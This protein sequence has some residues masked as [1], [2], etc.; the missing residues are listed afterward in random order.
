MDGTPRSLLDYLIK[1]GVMPNTARLVERGTFLETIS[2]IPEISSVAWTTIFTGTNPAEHGIFGFVDLQPHS[3]KIR[4][5]SFF[6]VRVPALWE[7]LSEKNRR[8]IIVNIPATYPAKPLLGKL[9]SGFVAIDLQKACWPK[10][11]AEEL[12]RAGYLID[13]DVSNYLNDREGLVRALEKSIEVRGRVILDLFVK[14]E[15]DLFW[16]VITETDRLHHFLFDAA[17]DEGHPL[18]K[19][20]V[21]VYG[22][23]DELLGEL[24]RRLDSRTRLFV[25]SDHGFTKVEREVNINFWLQE[26]GYL[27]FENSPPASLED[28]SSESIAFALDPARIFLNL[29]GRFPKGCVEPS[30]KERVVDKLACE[31]EKLESEDGKRIISR[32]FRSEEIYSGPLIDKAP[33]LV[34]VSNKGFDLKGRISAKNLFAKTHFAGMHTRDDAFLIASERR[35]FEHPLEIAKIYSILTQALEM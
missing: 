30:E 13:V 7:R 3:Y 28:I 4:F 12:E 34:L 18:H 1:K 31:L 17:F 10:E 9:V 25:F 2:S 14:E 33:D 32:I 22:K 19:A 35:A 26:N 6:D 24:L 21:E 27:K 16:A 8:S 23:I 29:K 15:F 20:F 11:W 5:P